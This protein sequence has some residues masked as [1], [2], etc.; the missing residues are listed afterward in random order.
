MN[1]DLRV[2]LDIR[3]FEIAMNDEVGMREADRA[4]HLHHQLQA[5]P[6]SRLRLSQ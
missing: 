6:T 5:C 3:G 2:H 4:R 1:L